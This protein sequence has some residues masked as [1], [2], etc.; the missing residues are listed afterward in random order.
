MKSETD[1]DI[2]DPAISRAVNSEDVIPV[3][4]LAP[5]RA[6]VQGAR[7]ALGEQLRQAC[8]TVGFYFIVNH[9]VPA[10]LIAQTFTE[11]ERFH[12]LPDSE[13]SRLAVNEH[14]IGYMGFKGST[15]RSSRVHV[16]T[17]PNLNEA[18]FLKRDLPADHPDVV[19]GKRFRGANQWPDEAA[20]P[21][22]RE[23]VTTYCAA[24]ERLALSLMPIYAA[25][26]DLPEDFFEDAFREPQYTLRM[27]HYPPVPDPEIEE[28]Q[29]AIAPHTDSGFM[30]LLPQND[31]PGLA[32]RKT[33]GTWIEPPAIPGSFLVNTGDLAR[34][35]TNHR[36]LSTPHRVVHRSM[37]D[38]Y[39]IP[40]FF[41][42][43]IDWPMACLPTCT[44]AN[45][46]PR[47]ATETYT[48]YMLWFGSQNYKHIKPKTDEK[49]ASVD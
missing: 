28:N 41:D 44:D 27:T 46:P 11:A 22:F 34:R 40:F 4:D 43:N 14:N 32:I 20:I 13:K 2:T 6:G 5:Y 12:A 10:D 29:Y 31:L 39:A 8:E 38:R 7:Q 16:N 36:F 19:A 1:A 24:A 18:L 30:T 21:G 23:N 25:A 47:Y 17:K 26:L 35:W 9:G 48:E 33:D 15:T 37:A 49:V 3:L 45:N 42:C